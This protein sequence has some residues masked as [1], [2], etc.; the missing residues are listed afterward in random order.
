MGTVFVVTGIFW[1]IAPQ[2]YAD[3]IFQLLSGGLMLGAF[4]M[5]TDMVTSPITPRGSYIFGIGAGIILVV[6]R[7][8]GGVPEGVMYSI[9]LMNAFTPIINRKTRPKIFGEVSA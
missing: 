8:F 2:S 9:L 1:L 3:P 5:A 7:L 4:Y 6:I